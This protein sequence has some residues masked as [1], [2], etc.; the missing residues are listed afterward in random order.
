MPALILKA[1]PP[2]LHRRL[3]QR[4]QIVGRT[5][6]QEAVLALER[7]LNLLRPAITLPEP[8]VPTRLLNDDLLAAA[9]TRH[10]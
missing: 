2:A 3:K 4:A 7:G 6:Q 1:I 10:R 5:V 9:R 8:V